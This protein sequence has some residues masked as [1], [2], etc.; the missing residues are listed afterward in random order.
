MDWVSWLVVG[1]LVAGGV[2]ALVLYVR[3]EVQRDPCRGCPG[4]SVRVQS[5]ARKREAR[6][7]ARLKRGAL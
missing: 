1:L 6:R 3:R 4:C 5:I 7:A 2:L